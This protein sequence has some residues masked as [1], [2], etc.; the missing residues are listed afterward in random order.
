[1]IFFVAPYQE[2]FVIVV[3][4]AASGRPEAAG[5]SGL[6]ETVAFLEEEMVVDQFL[7]H[8]LAH[9]GKRVK[10]ALVFAAQAGQCA[11]HLSLHFLVLGL[12]QAWVKWISF[13]GATTS[14]TS[15]YDVF[16]L[17]SI[18]TNTI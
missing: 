10:G 12:G 18:N 17:R 3:E 9:A 4:D 5:V 13:Q 6:E 2:G 7:L 8:L 1:M 15:G 14:Y 11:G 16:T